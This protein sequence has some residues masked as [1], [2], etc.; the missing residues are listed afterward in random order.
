M[1]LSVFAFKGIFVMTKSELVKAISEKSGSTIKN[2]D[3]VLSVI[4]EDVCYFGR[5]GL[6]VVY[7]D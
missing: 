3:K 1:L 6:G 5:I 4:F 7:W 2:T